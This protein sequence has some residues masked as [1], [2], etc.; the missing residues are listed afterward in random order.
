[1]LAK[2]E[3]NE[4]PQSIDVLDEHII[5]VGRTTRSL[6]ARLALFDGA[7]FGKG[8]PHAEG[9]TYK[10]VFGANQEGLY[11]SICPVYWTDKKVNHDVEEFVIKKVI[12]WLEVCLR[13][14]YVYK[15]GRL[16]KLNKE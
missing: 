11:V 1:M 13:G 10:K 7:A 8:A 4:T 16:P 12:T 15:W 3:S 6:K 2:Y 14:T 9:D 5:C